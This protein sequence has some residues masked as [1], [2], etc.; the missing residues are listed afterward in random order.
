MIFPFGV[1]RH[2]LAICSTYKVGL[3]FAHPT[4]VEMNQTPIPLYDYQELA[5]Q[6]AMQ[7]NFGI[8]QSAAGSGKTQMGLAL[9]QR[10]GRKALWITHTWDLLKQSKERA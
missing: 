9:I 6:Q 7:Q 8:L 2:L 1:L 4:L 10:F 3:C 5:V